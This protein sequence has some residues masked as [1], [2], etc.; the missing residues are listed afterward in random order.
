M[1]LFTREREG[2]SYQWL[3]DGQ[4]IPGARNA[5]LMAFQP[6][7]YQVRATNG[8]CERISGP[9][10]LV[11]CGEEGKLAPPVAVVA[12]PKAGPVD[13]S[14]TPPTFVP[15]MEEDIRYAAD[16]SPKKLKNRKIKPQNDIL[17]RNSKAVIYV[18][19]HASAD[20]DTISLNI[21]GEWVLEEYELVKERIAIEFEFQPG[22]NYIMLYAHN[23]GTTPPNTASVMVDD[24]VRRQ[25]MQLRST[26]R[27]C[28][29]L[30]VRRAE[31]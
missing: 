8:Q 31:D 2:V 14:P 4:P 1:T 9:Q 16:G 22:N 7:S 20:R 3:K 6:G 21:N 18:W 19:D 25:T 26:L 27:N 12:P 28:G 23:L 17:I 11:R 24:G 10:Q 15:K 13:I 5:S 30:T 29:S